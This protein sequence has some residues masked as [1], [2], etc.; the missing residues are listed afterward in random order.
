MLLRTYL[1][2]LT[3]FLVDVEFNAGILFFRFGCCISRKYVWE[4]VYP[5]FQKAWWCLLFLNLGIKT[6]L[7]VIVVVA[8]YILD[9]AEGG[10]WHHHRPA[11][12]L[13][14]CF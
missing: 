14:C 9:T 5:D 10:G 6:R 4:Y 8:C 1:S 2:N 11:S 7:L 12:E 13:P 3:S